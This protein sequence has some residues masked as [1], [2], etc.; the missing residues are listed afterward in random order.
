M[1]IRAAMVACELFLIVVI[2]AIAAILLGS[3]NY[4]EVPM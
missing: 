2:I 4:N 1:V 3:S